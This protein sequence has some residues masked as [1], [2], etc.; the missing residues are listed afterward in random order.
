MVRGAG[1]E[2]R[3]AGEG[4]GEEVRGGPDGG[5]TELGAGAAELVGGGG[6][7]GW[8]F[9]GIIPCTFF[10]MFCSIPVSTPERSEL[11][12]LEVAGLSAVLLLSISLSTSSGDCVGE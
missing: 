10:S 5:D 11:P 6:D 4:E 9:A 12:S 3:G 8:L 1:V 2:V 7:N